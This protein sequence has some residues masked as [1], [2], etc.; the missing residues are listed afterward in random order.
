MKTVSLIWSIYC[1]H[2]TPNI[3]EQIKLGCKAFLGLKKNTCTS[4]NRCTKGKTVA[5]I[6]AAKHTSKLMLLHFYNKVPSLLKFQ[7]SSLRFS[8]MKNLFFFFIQEY[9]YRSRNVSY[10]PWAQIPFNAAIKLTNMNRPFSAALNF[11]SLK[12]SLDKPSEVKFPMD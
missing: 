2:I 10:I 9:W 11:P 12:W 6:K 5:M 7:Q 1:I 3:S 8:P 4:Q